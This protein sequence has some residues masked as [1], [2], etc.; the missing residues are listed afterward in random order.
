[1][2]TKSLLAVFVG[3]VILPLSAHAQ[4][5]D[6]PKC[7]TECGWNDLVQLASNIITFLLLLSIPV[8]TIAFAWAGILMLTASGSEGQVEKAKEIFW[9]VL[10]GFIF[11]LTAWLIVWTITNTLLKEGSY[12]DL[13]RRSDLPSESRMI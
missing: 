2:K 13:L 7:G 6:I 8:A 1:M 3:S 11:A 10:K 12:V 5:L 4:I 9:K